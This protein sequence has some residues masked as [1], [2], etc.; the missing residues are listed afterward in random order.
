MS[1]YMSDIVKV[2]LSS[3][4]L[5]ANLWYFAIF[6]KIYLYIGFENTVLIGFHPDPGV[7]MGLT[8][9]C[10]KAKRNWADSDIQIMIKI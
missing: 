4:E 1:E 5:A 6:D 9:R 2:H 3:Y 8:A 7:R 10:R